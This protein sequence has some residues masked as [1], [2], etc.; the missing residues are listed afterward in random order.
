[1]SSAFATTI[2]AIVYIAALAPLGLAA[3]KPGIGGPLAAIYGA[4]I[5]AIAAHQSGI[6]A[7]PALPS[8]TDV[9]AAD[10]TMSE[11]RCTELLTLLDNGGVILDRRAP[12]R[13]A[14]AQDGWEQLPAEAR[15]AIVACVQRAWPRNSAPAQV[16]IRTR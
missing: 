1:M 15:E 8:L 9:S 16:E 5:T 4:F 14:V 11:A 3:W 6:F 2:V 13:L 7:Q 10:V 12:P